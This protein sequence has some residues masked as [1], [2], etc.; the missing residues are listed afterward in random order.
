[1][2]SLDEVPVKTD[3]RTKVAVGAVDHTVPSVFNDLK[4][5]TDQMKL[6]VSNNLAKLV[7]EEIITKDLVVIKDVGAAV[8]V[9]VDHVEHSITVILKEVVVA[10]VA[11]V[12]IS[13]TEMLMKVRNS[14]SNRN[15][16]HKTL[17]N[18]N[19]I[20]SMYSIAEG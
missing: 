11:V 16:K 17:V 4:D 3:Q 10:V 13:I 19:Q 9:V 20:L 15:H 6:V 14:S 12:A 8:I 7:K 1:M 2:V 5:N 18:G